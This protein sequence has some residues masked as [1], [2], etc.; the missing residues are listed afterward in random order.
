MKSYIK[1]YPN[2]CLLMLCYALLALKC[3]ILPLL[4]LALAHYDGY[5]TEGSLFRSIHPVILLIFLLAISVL[6]ISFF[7]VRQS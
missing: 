2:L 1:K 4:D 3:I 7:E 6:F 5:K